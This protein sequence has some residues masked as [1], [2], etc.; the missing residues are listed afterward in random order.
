MKI[1]IGMVLFTS[2]SVFAQTEEKVLDVELTSVCEEAERQLEADESLSPA[3]QSIQE[4]AEKN[5][6][7]VVVNV[8]NKQSGG[9][10]KIRFHFG[11]S[12][13]FGSIR[14]TTVRLRSSGFNAD[15]KDFQFDERT[16][17]K[18]F[19]PS[20]WEGADEALKW[21]DEPTNTMT[22]SI[23]N[24]KDVIYL[25]AYHPKMIKTYN[26]E[27]GDWGVHLQNTHKNM[28]WQIGYGRK[29]K[30]FEGRKGATLTYIPRIDAGFQTGAANSNMFYQGAD[31]EQND[32]FGLQGFNVSLGHRLEYQKGAMG[33][34][35]E[36]RTQLT[37]TKQGFM[38]GTATYTTVY[39][40]TTFGISFDLFTSGKKKR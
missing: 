1:L 11:H 36:N 21:I 4:I 16:S 14:P 12:R 35:I 15:I 2:L 28:V 31:Y 7:P 30:I 32:K 8:E 39:S 22:F 18:Y 34:F 10:W 3:C 40:P 38:D 25:T 20:K 27:S 23:E 13:M 24:D 6:A 9:R 33:V 17:D 26:D 29:F 5:P 19:N 37:K